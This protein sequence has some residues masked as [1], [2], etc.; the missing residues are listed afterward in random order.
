MAIDIH[1]EDL[2]PVSGVPKILTTRP[3]V[4]S[5]WRWVYVGVRG[6]RLE[7]VIVGGRR[8]TSREAVDRFVSQTTASADGRPARTRTEKQRERA[9]AAAEKELE[10]M[11]I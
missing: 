1:T 4:S 6:I 10:R 3:H 8:Y 5:C 9:I 7:T 2:M 11:G